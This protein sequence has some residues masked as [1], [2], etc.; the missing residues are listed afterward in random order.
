MAAGAQCGQGG[1]STGWLTTTWP[2]EAGEPFT[3]TLHIHDTG[4]G[5]L[6]SLVLIDN[7]TWEGAPVTAGTGA[8][9]HN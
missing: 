8:A 4:D 6:D 9:S 3:L 2:I 7:F 1:S 5:Q